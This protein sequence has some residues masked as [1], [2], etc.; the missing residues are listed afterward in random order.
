MLINEN[1]GIVKSIQNNRIVVEL[2]RGGTFTFT[3]DREFKVGD[4]VCFRLDTVHQKVT[5]V[6]PKQEAEDIVQTADIGGIEG[7]N[8]SDGEPEPINHTEHYEE[9]EPIDE[10]YIDGPR[11][12]AEISADWLDG[13]DR[14]TFEEPGSNAGNYMDGDP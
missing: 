12:N 6:I 5:S 7:F 4:P 3:A 10:P 8:P 2:P 14:G 1:K 11:S 9:E 13:E